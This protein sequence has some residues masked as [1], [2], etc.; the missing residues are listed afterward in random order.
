VSA[1]KP[2]LNLGCGADRHPAFVNV[3]LVAGPGV[4]GHD[5]RQGIPFPDATFDLVYHSTMLSHLRPSDALGLMRECYRVLKAGGVL[6]VVT[7]DLEQMCRVYLQKLEAACL[8]DRDS[9][10][11][12]EWMIL[13]LYDQ[14]TREHPGGG[15]ADYFGQDPLPNE[16]F[17]YSRVGEQGRRMVAGARSRARRTASRGGLRPL[18]STLRARARKL[19]LTGLLGRRGLLAFETGTFRLSS[20]QVTYRMYDRYSLQRL[21]LDAGFS[22]VSVRTATES[23][24]ACWNEVNLDVSQPG[25]AARPHALIMEGVKSGP[26]GARAA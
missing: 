25:Q 23:A 1:A 10:K 13:E 21:F 14:A 7:E 3:D 16:A 18:L 19:V 4:L 20:G 8:G 6:R 2:L 24:Y 22:N 15:M 26:S 9:E 5:L 12:Y 17:I 11:D